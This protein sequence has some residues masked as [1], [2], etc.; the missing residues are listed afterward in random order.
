MKTVGLDGAVDVIGE[1]VA[2][3]WQRMMCGGLLKHGWYATKAEG[4][5]GE[6]EEKCGE[7]NGEF[8]WIELRG[9]EKRGDV[10]MYG[11]RCMGV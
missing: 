6:A 7:N 1:G 5:S 3:L 9:L 11:D 2:G 4:M 8:C 10:E